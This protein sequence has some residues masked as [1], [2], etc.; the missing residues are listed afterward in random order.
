MRPRKKVSLWT[1]ANASGSGLEKPGRLGRAKEPFAGKTAA[2]TALPDVLNYTDYRQYLNDY[3]QAQKSANPK[4]SLRFLAK[5][6]NFASHGLLKFL[7]EG[8]RNL[9]KK[10]LVKLS[11]A[12]GLDKARASYFENLVFFNQ[13]VD[14]EEKGLYYEK[15]LQTPGKSS[16]KNL[17]YAQL[18]I[19]RK[20]YTIAIREMI[21]SKGF[22]ISPEWIAGRFLPKLDAREAAEALDVLLTTGLVRKTANGL[23]TV[24]PD[25][26]TNDE[27]KS[28]M[29]M[30]YH[31]QMMKVAAWAQEGIPGRD[32]DISSACFSI[33][34]ADLPN[35]KKQLQLMRKELRNF[36]AKEGEGERIVQVNIQMFPLTR[37]G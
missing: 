24:D 23:K 34:E 19:F 29:V 10:T 35:L 28:F 3:Y 16:F 18:Q 14:L 33:R 5:K 1:M 2:G 32:R 26:T 30:G 22:R 12:L 31:D 13:A 36:A 27:V 8:K 37:G 7:M 15:L 21:N 6:A 9:S 4:F 20:W 11:P 17:Q 25:I